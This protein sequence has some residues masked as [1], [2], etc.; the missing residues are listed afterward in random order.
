MSLIIK[1]ENKRLKIE[2][3]EHHMFPIEKNSFMQ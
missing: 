2:N 3:A 1:N